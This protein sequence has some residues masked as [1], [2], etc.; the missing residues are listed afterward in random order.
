MT[1][2]PAQDIIEVEPVHFRKLKKTAPDG[3][4]GWEERAFVALTKD[5]A[6]VRQW[7]DFHY[8]KAKY[9]NTWWESSD[10]IVMSEKIYIHYMLCL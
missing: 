1:F 4:S 7:L 5:V 3:N 6:G 9:C 8:G 2:F 10:T